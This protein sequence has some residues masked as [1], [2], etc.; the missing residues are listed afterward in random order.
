MLTI[1]KNHRTMVDTNTSDATN[2]NTISY[3][4]LKKYCES[5]QSQ[6][7]Y[8]FLESQDAFENSLGY[9]AI[10]LSCSIVYDLKVVQVD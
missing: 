1:I 7:Y 8:K 5:L 6:E 10:G 4:T 9:L 2:T 3:D